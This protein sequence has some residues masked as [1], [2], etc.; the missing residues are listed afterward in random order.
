MNRD[1]QNTQHLFEAALGGDRLSF[2]KNVLHKSL[3]LFVTS[4]LP[5]P[6]EDRTLIIHCGPEDLLHKR[7][8]TLLELAPEKM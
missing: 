1:D 8:A 6:E 5:L 7:V 2:T 4:V 3:Q